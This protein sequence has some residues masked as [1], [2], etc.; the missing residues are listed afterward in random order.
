MA[1]AAGDLLNFVEATRALFAGDRDRLDV[2]TLTWPPDVRSEVLWR[3][4]TPSLQE[5]EP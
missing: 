5:K 4:E 2:L 1:V 3:L